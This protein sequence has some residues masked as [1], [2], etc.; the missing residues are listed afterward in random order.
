MILLFSILAARAQDLTLD[1]ALASGSSATEVRGG[2][3]TGSGW[4]VDN[5]GD[6]LFWDLGTQV[7]RGT[8][9]FTLDAV[10]L[11]N[12]TGDNNHI[13]EL[14]D[15][16]DHWSCSRAINV[17]V[18][19]SDNPADHGDIK[20]KVWEPGGYAE[21]RGG[22]QVWDGLPHSFTV[23]WDADH[24]ALYR[25]GVELV[26]LDTTGLD[27]RMGTLWLPLASWGSGYSAPLGSV[28]RDLH[29]EAWEP[30][31]DGG[32]GDG[33]RGDGGDDG[34]PS[35]F[36]PIED[37]GLISSGGSDIED[38]PV[39]GAGGSP[40]EVSYLMFDLSSLSG[41]V[42]SASLRLQVR[43]DG[44]AGG[45]SGQVSAVA[46]GVARRRVASNTRTPKR[47]HPTRRWGW[48]AIRQVDAGAERDPGKAAFSGRGAR[49]S[50][51]R[52]HRR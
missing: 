24:A 34:D 1:E 39:Q 41:D 8:V 15:A 14:F 6:G 30:A 52:S 3:F 37:V 23:S 43:A 36:G 10:T 26:W 11:A 49:P 28:Y 7:D 27:L 31:G 46:A 33:G 32:S 40:S 20:L 21:A 29:L 19:G 48:V 9:S 22:I 44:S 42:V 18:Y 16:G 5:S 2:T 13:V 50:D 47:P 35:T 38:L 4:R 45:S 17:R 51:D 25:D 12:L